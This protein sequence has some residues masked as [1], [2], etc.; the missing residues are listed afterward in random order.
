MSK[1]LH[2]LRET[3][4]IGQREGTFLPVQ[5]D[6]NKRK[7]ANSSPNSNHPS[8][9]G[10]GDLSVENVKNKINKAKKKKKKRQVGEARPR[11]GCASGRN[12]KPGSRG[13]VGISWLSMFQRSLGHLAW[14]SPWKQNHRKMDAPVLVLRVGQSFAAALGAV[15]CWLTHKAWGSECCLMMFSE[16]FVRVQ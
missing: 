12:A 9:G 14:Y 4:A 16:L 6:K 2:C 7:L 11:K 8:K 5:G 1:P 10:H 3:I 15:A 13:T